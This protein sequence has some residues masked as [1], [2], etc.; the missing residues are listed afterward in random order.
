M[1]KLKEKMKKN[2]ENSLKVKKSHFNWC[3]T[4]CFEVTN[5]LC[6]TQKSKINGILSML[7]LV[8]DHK[9][10]TLMSNIQQ[11]ILVKKKKKEQ[12]IT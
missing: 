12:L 3:E 1:S 10:V 2:Q 7:V 5:F 9:T 11:S 8:M 4:F 6:D